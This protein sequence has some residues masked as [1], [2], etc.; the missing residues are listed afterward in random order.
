MKC[1]PVSTSFAI[2]LSEYYGFGSLTSVSE[3][4]YNQ[5]PKWYL[6][7]NSLMCVYFFFPFQVFISENKSWIMFSKELEWFLCIF[8]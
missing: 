1:L 4:K 2:S 7:I 3:G 6:V 8:P 5:I